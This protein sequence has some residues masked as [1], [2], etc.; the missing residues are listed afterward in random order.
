MAGRWLGSPWNADFVDPESNRLGSS[1][2]VYYH[3]AP[4]PTLPQ[5]RLE[6]RH[7][8]PRDERRVGQALPAGGNSEV[9]EVASPPSLVDGDG[10][11]VAVEDAVARESGDPG[12]GVTMPTRFRG[13]GGGDRHKVARRNARAAC[14][15]AATEVPPVGG[16]PAALGSTFRSATFLPHLT[17]TM[18]H[19]QEQ[20]STQSIFV[21]G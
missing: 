4:S 9:D 8:R 14:R 7:H 1:A 18:W 3:P 19:D 12:A 15:P 20:P 17:A 2:K 10:D 11:A 6:L 16:Q 21:S 13:V 5:V